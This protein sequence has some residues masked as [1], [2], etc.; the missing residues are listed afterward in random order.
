[1]MFKYNSIFSNG[2][3]CE[4]RRGPERA[5]QARETL[6]SAPPARIPPPPPPPPPAADA[7]PENGMK[8]TSRRGLLA[9]MAGGTALWYGLLNSGTPVVGV[10]R[11]RG[12]ALLRTKGGNVVAA[13]QDED[14]RVFIFDKA[15]N[16]YYDTEDAA[17]GMYIVDRVGD[18]FNEYVDQ[19]GQVQQVYVGNLK[20]IQSVKVSE[21]G[22]I[23]VEELR[24]SIKGFKGGQVVGFPK[25]P[26]R[27]E[28]TW[29]NLMPPNAPTMR[30]RNGDIVKVPPMLEEFEIE[31]DPKSGKEKSPS[32]YSELL[33]VF[34]SL[35][36]E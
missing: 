11:K 33:G 34:K 12:L 23:S 6:P 8:G 20:D 35:R 13:A 26:G 15:G 32:S 14:G 2:S 9:I 30:N 28:L 17:T 16:I 19:D 10:D 22:G 36:R 3:R 24:R 29:E 31:L 21:I 7:V 27:E 18:T 5:K 1:M 25:L 4:Y